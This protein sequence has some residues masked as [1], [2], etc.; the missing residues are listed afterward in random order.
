M[1]TIC[2][3]CTILVQNLYSFCALFIQCLNSFCKSFAYK[4]FLQF[5]FYLVFLWILSGFFLNLY[6]KCIAHDGMVQN[7]S[8]YR[9]LRPCPETS[10]PVWS[11][12]WRR[13][14]ASAHDPS[15]RIRASGGALPFTGITT[16]VDPKERLPPLSAPVQIG[17]NLIQIY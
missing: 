16:A 10:A 17:E 15:P 6:G 11:V 2:R 1:H 4:N 14:P 13:Q 7:G 5:F 12:S 3:M 8:P 9:V